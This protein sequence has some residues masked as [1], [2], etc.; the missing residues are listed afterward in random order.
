M[1]EKLMEALTSEFQSKEVL[2]SKLG[3]SDRE[4]RRLAAELRKKGEPIFSSS[5]TKG[6]KIGTRQEMMH[7]RAECMKRSR[8]LQEIARAIEL[9]ELE[10]Q[11]KINENH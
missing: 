6:Y 9:H 8:E 2:M 1:K 10:G 11:M 7:L 4:L 5:K 3:I